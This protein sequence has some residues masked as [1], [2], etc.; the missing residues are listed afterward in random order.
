MA[1]RNELVAH[2]VTTQELQTSGLR[3]EAGKAS[4]TYDS[5]FAT[6]NESK[7]LLLTKIILFVQTCALLQQNITGK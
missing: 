3:A 2:R 6:I 7:L 5:I 4:H 1:E